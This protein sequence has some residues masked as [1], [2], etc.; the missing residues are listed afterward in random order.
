[1]KRYILLISFIFSLVGCE[2]M[3]EKNPLGQPGSSTFYK[4]QSNYLEGLTAA[5]AYVHHGY[6]NGAHRPGNRGDNMSD[7]VIWGPKANN[8]NIKSLH[9]FTYSVAQAG[10]GPWWGQYEA[11]SLA[12]III[13][14]ITDDQDERSES[15]RGEAFFLRGW[16]YANLAIWYG[17]AV[18][19]TKNAST[20]EEYQREAVPFEKVFEQALAD[21]AEAEKRLPVKWSNP[22]A[23]AGR[24]TKGTAL[25]YMA[26]AYLYLKDWAKA[27]E[28]AKKVIDLGAYSL[29]PNYGSMF[30]LAGENGTESIF[31]AQYGIN[32]AQS[33]WQGNQNNLQQFYISGGVMDGGKAG[34]SGSSPQGGYQPSPDLL[35][36]YELK[37][38]RRKAIFIFPGDTVMIDNYRIIT[39]TDL[40]KFKSTW[41]ETGA[42]SKKWLC[43]P[44]GCAMKDPMKSTQNW[45]HMRYAEVL[46]MYA[47]AL[48][49]QGKI[50]EAIVPLNQVRQRAGLDAIKASDVNQSTLRDAVRLEYR[51]EFALEG[52]RAF[53]VC[54]WG[55]IP[56]I[57]IDRGF[58]IGK[59]EHHPI[60]E[61]EIDSNK[62]LTQVEGW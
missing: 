18:I 51:R 60:P 6:T 52:K 30:T 57:M 34:Y 14:E 48:T 50:A 62:K 23:N 61:G 13:D 58:V 36:K 12:N 16:E 22:S 47:E 39:P 49:E 31:E 27:A 38:K 20:F 41:S 26:Q 17:K 59:H 40:A 56:Q 8:N 35:S 10:T 53:L 33:G 3:L 37:D 45:I 21:Y 5:Y 43:P 42:S 32:P 11:I 19:F 1:M 7:D 9:Y 25:A 2:D 46:L 54:R 28:Y 55:Q 4:T 15:A 44:S 29:V 24:V